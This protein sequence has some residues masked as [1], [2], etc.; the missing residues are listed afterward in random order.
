MI[1]KEWLW[2]EDEKGRR[3]GR[4]DDFVTMEIALALKLGKVVI[5][6][7]INGVPPLREQDLPLILRQLWKCNALP[8]AHDR[9][10]GDVQKI[11]ETVGHH[12]GWSEADIM[13]ALLGGSSNGKSQGVWEREFDL[14]KNSSDR[15]EFIEF[16]RTNPPK[17]V[18]GLAR[19]ALEKLDWTTVGPNPNI[20]TLEWFLRSHPD[21]QYAPEARQKLQQLRDEARRQ[22]ERQAQFQYE[23]RQ[24]AEKQAEAAQRKKEKRL[25]TRR[26][27]LQGIGVA[28]IAAGGPALYSTVIT[29]EYIWHKLHVRTLAGHT[30]FVLSAAFSPDG[31]TLAS[32]SSDKTVKLWDVASGRELRTLAGHTVDV[33]SV[34]FSPDGRTLALGQRGQN[35]QALGCCQ[36]ARAAH[37]RRAH[38]HGH[39]RRVLARWPDAGL[40]QRGQHGQALGCCQRARAAHPRRAYGLGQLR[41]RSR[42]MAGC[43]PRAA[44]TTTVKLWDVASGRE[45]RTLA[46]HTDS[47]YSVAFSPDGALLASGSGDKTV[48]LWDVASGREL[49][50]LAGHTNSVNSVAFSPDGRTLASGSGDKT[51]KLWDVASG[52][53]LRTLAGHTNSVDSVAFSPD[54]RTLA[55]GSWDYRVKL[56]DVSPYLAAR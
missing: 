37:P 16:L 49:R 32:G 17:D 9:F 27:V 11:A 21:S 52:R 40:G 25:A 43:W 10:P 51:V 28:I 34:A 30:N 24:R 26:R 8:L 44:G 31:W 36:R 54:G 56:W 1:G 35:G 7:L 47:V 5:P 46:G 4:A 48:K 6:V 42:P 15:K 33:L 13:K 41:S 39:F 19:K 14:I 22:A 29:G 18:A 20:E 3:L 23:A 55:S 50:T 12:L 45:L 2:L 53:E 38:G